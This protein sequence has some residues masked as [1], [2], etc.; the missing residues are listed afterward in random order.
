MKWI[1][2]SGICLG[3]TV[4]PLHWVFSAR[5]IKPTDMD[6]CQYGFYLSAGLVW[7]R[8]WIDNGDW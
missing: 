4:N 1:R 5:L 3:V 6:P 8:V 2:Y 7:L